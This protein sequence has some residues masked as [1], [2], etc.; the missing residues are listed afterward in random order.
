LKS[1]TADN[2]LKLKDI[3]TVTQLTIFYVPQRN[4]R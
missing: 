4:K 3:F 2:S 1:I